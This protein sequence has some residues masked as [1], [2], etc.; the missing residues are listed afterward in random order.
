MA[1][2]FHGRQF[3]CSNIVPAY[4][5]IQ[6][7]HFVCDSQGARPGRWTV[8]GDD[9][10]Q[11]KY[12]YSYS[13]VWRNLGILCAFGIGFLMLY[14]VAIELN[15]SITSGGE[16]LLFRRGH[17]ATGAAAREDEESKG[18]KYNARCD[19]DS[20][21]GIP[22][23]QGVLAWKDVTYDVEV[24]GQRRRLLDHVAGWVKPGTLTALM[25]ASGAGKTTLLDVLAQRVRV[26]VVS[27]Q[28]SVNGR[29]LDSSFA[30]KTGYVQQ[31][32]S[33]VSDFGVRIL[34]ADVCRFA[35]QHSYCSRELAL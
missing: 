24:H 19:S 12:G 29:G 34:C 20:S 5:D 27:G 1:N 33:A 25:G 9:F 10:I 32:G 14:F 8:S 35:P 18:G 23:Q 22:P 16:I 7:P 21:T 13:H 26:G 17:C 11:V 30:R 15:S 3:T 2:E 4:A 6:S 28:I 31:Q